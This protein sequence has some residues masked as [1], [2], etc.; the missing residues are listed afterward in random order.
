MVGLVVFT[1]AGCKSKSQADAS[2]ASVVSPDWLEGRLP[3]DDGAPLD[4]GTLI[5]RLMGEPSALN[6]I[7]NGSH[8]AVVQRV[9]MRLV[10]EPLIEIDAAGE[11][12]PALAASWDESADHLTVRFHLRT[13]A[14]F[15]SG[16][17]FTAEDAIVTFDTIMS[18]THPTG[19]TRS[20]LGALTSWKAIDA[21][22]LEL[23]WSAASVFAL[24]ALASVPM[25]S[26]AQLK[27]EWSAIGQKP[28][29]TGPF[30][31]SKWERGTSI[32]LHRR[33]PGRAYLEQIIFRFVKDHTAANALFERGEI[34]LMTNILPSTW[35]AVE[36]SEWATRDWNRVKSIDNSY[37]Y[38]G[39][40]E[41][42]PALADVRVRR[43]FAHLYDAKLINR[44]VDLDLE[45]PTTCPYLNGSDSCSSSV[46]PIPF[47]IEAARRELADAGVENL[48]LRFL[49][50]SSSVRLGKLVPL[51]QEQFRAAGVELEIENVETT[52]LSTR[53]SK[54]DF[55]VV[56]RVWTEFDREQ[57]LFP[58]FHSSQ[59]DGGQNYV[60]YTNAEADRLI[61]AIRSEFDVTKRRALERA[62][63]E[64][65][66]SDQPYLFMTSRQSLDAAKKHVHGLTPSLRWYDLRAVWVSH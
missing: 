40:N 66:A 2:F 16:A 23:T 51:L 8:D 60:G 31:I 20:E 36:K 65:L 12:K 13:D 37:S 63:H 34:D 5:V 42:V 39:W 48:R 14:T 35:R 21:Q 57:D 41:S 18:G 52:T 4:G 58:M 1:T 19:S 44:I 11:L 17:A 56:S 54:R 47:S 25:L 64:R 38:I 50:P 10:L 53:T 61:E 62:L 9:A 33:A 6:P 30:E 7:D 49:L 22:T 55:E 27:G 28:I 43:A 24:R 15:S 46:T 32:T 45:V 26:A 3:R 29:G 59:I